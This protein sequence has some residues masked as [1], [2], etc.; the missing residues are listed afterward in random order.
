MVNMPRG[1]GIGSEGRSH[2]EELPFGASE[3]GLGFS[4]F[5]VQGLGLTA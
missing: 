2:F 5:R 3:L 4:R 1:P